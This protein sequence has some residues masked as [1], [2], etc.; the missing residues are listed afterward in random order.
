MPAGQ[1]IS[2]PQTKL[3]QG[4]TPPTQTM[5]LQEGSPAAKQG[6]RLCHRKY[7]II[8]LHN[9]T[10]QIPT[11][12]LYLE[13]RKRQFCKEFSKLIAHGVTWSYRLLYYRV[14]FRVALKYFLSKHIVIRVPCSVL[15]MEKAHNIYYLSFM[16]F[17]YHFQNA[18]SP[19]VNS[20]NFLPLSQ[21][22]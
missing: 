2:L 13:R 6:N 18:T 11:H 22:Q 12:K 10:K 19:D 3:T 14:T 21:Y 15:W 7:V 16:L 4:W 1:D 17:D 5:T 20:F 8:G 9:I